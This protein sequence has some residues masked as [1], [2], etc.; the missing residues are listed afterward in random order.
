MLIIE[1]AC[2]TCHTCHRDFPPSFRTYPACKKP[3]RS[4]ILTAG[5]ILLASRSVII[6]YLRSGNKVEIMRNNVQY[7]IVCLKTEVIPSG[8]PLRTGCGLDPSGFSQF[9]KPEPGSV[10]HGAVQ[11][12]RVPPGLKVVLHHIPGCQRHVIFHDLRIVDPSALP[13]L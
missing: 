9:G 3:R 7:T 6:S 1:I 12:V 10:T 8:A 2:H 13:F 4:F 11:S 5:M